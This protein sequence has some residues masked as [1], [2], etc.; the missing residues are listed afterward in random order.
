[1]IGGTFNPPHNGHLRLARKV[2]ERL[3]YDKVVFIPAFIPPHKEIEGNTSAEQRLAMI[4]LAV[5][6]CDWAVTEDVEIARGGVSF[7]IDT[8]AY[9]KA[10]YDCLKPALV[11]G[12]DHVPIF[13]TWKEPDRLAE[14]ADIVVV[15]RTGADRTGFIWP[16]RFINLEPDHISSARIRDLAAKGDMSGVQELVPEKVFE[17]IRSME[18]YRGV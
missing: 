2:L 10:K 16:H 18:L 12:D 5:E 3:D 17:Y 13:H 8:V 9:L 14:E 6:D 11:V 1:M 7:T 4:R 15:N